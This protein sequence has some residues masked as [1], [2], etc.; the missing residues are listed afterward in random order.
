MEDSD[1]YKR[2]WECRLW[3]VFFFPQKNDF[4]QILGPKNGQTKLR[5]DPRDPSKKIRSEILFIF[6]V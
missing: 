1:Y 5:Y 2:L 6:R 4:S 3:Y